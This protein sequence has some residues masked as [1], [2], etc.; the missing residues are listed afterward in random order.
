MCPEK[1]KVFLIDD[2]FV[3]RDSLRRVLTLGGHTVV[4]EAA[5]LDQALAAIERMKE[6]GV[7]VVFVDGKLSR[8]YP[9]NTE[10]EQVATAIRARYPDGDIKTIGMSAEPISGVDVDLGK[11]ASYSEIL[12][13]VKRL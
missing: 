7:Q 13:T 8:I 5:S 12:E 2:K 4:G 10:G 11:Q 6:L 9:D 3:C 1:A